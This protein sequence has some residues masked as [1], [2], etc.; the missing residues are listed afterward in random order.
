MP[1]H[2]LSPFDDLKNGSVRTLLP[3]KN[4]IN[5][6]RKELFHLVECMVGKEEKEAMHVQN[7]CQ[8][9]QHSGFE[10]YPMLEKKGNINI[11]TF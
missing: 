8:D 3:L 9:Q 6:Q 10:C 4:D 2:Q 11:S 5:K 1:E 7:S